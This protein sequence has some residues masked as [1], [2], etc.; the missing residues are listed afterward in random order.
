MRGHLDEDVITILG[1]TAHQMKTCDTIL[2]FQVLWTMWHPS[3]SD[4]VNDT[5]VTYFTSVVSF[6]SIYNI[7]TS[8]GRIY[9]HKLN[10]IV[11][12]ELF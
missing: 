12:A 11:V 7:S 10:N 4:I 1:L 3:K 5:R 6:T 8:Q 9:G 2:L